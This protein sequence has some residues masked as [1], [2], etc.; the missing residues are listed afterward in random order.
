MSYVSL[1]HFIHNRQLPNCTHVLSSI[2][3][4][5]V[6]GEIWRHV[7]WLGLYLP[8]MSVLCQRHHTLYNSLQTAGIICKPCL[9]AEDYILSTECIYVSYD[10]QKNFISLNSMQPLISVMAMRCEVSVLSAVEKFSIVRDNQWPVWCARQPKKKP[11]VA[12]LGLSLGASVVYTFWRVA[13]RTWIEKVL[14]VWLR[15]SASLCM[16]IVTRL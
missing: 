9:N 15:N 3:T 4:P 16:S 10:R 14:S 5:M 12:P 7:C 8:C 1:T 13:V 6:I 2:E 11:T